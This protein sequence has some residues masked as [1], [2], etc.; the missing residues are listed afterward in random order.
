MFIYIHLPAYVHDV[1]NPVM[2][3]GAGVS[4]KAPWVL[5]TRHDTRVTVC[6]DCHEGVGVSLLTRLSAFDETHT[7]FSIT[8][9][10]DSLF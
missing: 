3:K 4:T 7:P 1:Q 6:F 2:E 9:V 8:L 10:G 5:L